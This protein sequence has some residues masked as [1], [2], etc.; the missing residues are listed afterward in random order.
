MPKKLLSSL[1]IAGLALTL[2]ACSPA[3][4]ETATADCDVTESGESSELIEVSGEQGAVPEVTFESPLTPTTTERSVITEGEGTAAVAGSTV[5]VDYTAFNGTTGE[6]I[7]ATGY[8][9]EGT[10]RFTLD[11]EQ[12][13]PGLLKAMSCSTAGE[14]VAAVIPPVD[15]FGDTGNEA[16]AVGAEDSLVF[17]IDVIEVA[18]P[19][20]A[21]PR[22]E[23]EAVDPV[24]GLPTVELAEDGEP[25][26]TVPATEAPTELLIEP[27]IIGDGDVVESGDNVTV[28]YT[29]MKWTGEIFD[30]SW[31]RG[32]P[33]E[34]TT[35]EGALIEGFRAAIVGQTVGSQ[36]IAVIPPADGYGEAGQGD[37]TGTDTLVFV[38][39]IL[40]TQ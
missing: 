3:E 14:R 28:H 30:S 12:L 2:V 22:A 33:A 1:A 13:L 24:E 26:I 8:D 11:A 27:L 7:E 29:G 10:Q 32:E 17:V 39:D 23:G 18:E 9:E 20:E 35:A 31:E 21:L 37:I 34:F 6:E 25:T 40:A 4:E 19:V 5:T 16:L 15:A 38:A 36:V